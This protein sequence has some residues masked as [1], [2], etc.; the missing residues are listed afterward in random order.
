MKRFKD[1][2]SHAVTLFISFIINLLFGCDKKEGEV[3]LSHPSCGNSGNMSLGN[4]INVD[5]VLC[6]FIFGKRYGNRTNFIFS[7]NSHCRAPDTG[8]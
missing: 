3:I 7:A 8:S 2:F 1:D 6:K 4:E 5:N